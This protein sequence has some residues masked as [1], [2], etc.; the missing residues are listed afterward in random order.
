MSDH[1][2]YNKWRN[3]CYKGLFCG[4]MLCPNSPINKCLK[5]YFIIALNM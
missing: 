1:I 4:I 3:N 2:E 5:C